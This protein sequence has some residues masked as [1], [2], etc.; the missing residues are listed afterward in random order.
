[1]PADLFTRRPVSGDQASIT[2]GPYQAAIA[3][4]G[5]S[6]RSLTY[7]GRELVAG[8]EANALRPAFRGAVLVPWPNRIAD[9]RYVF[10][11]VEYQVPLNEPERGNALHGLA[12]WADWQIGERDASSVTF[13]YRLVAQQAYPADLGVQATYRLDDQGLHWSVRATNLG[14]VRAPFALGSHAYLVAGPGHVDDWTLKVPAAAV[15]EVTPDRLLPVAERTVASFEG[16][17]LDFRRPRAIGSTFIDHAFTDVTARADRLARVEL[18]TPSGEG[19]AM[20]WDP[21]QLPWVQVHTADRPEPELNRSGLAVEPMT[22][23]PDAFN[24]G[25]DLIVLEPGASFASSWT[26][27]ALGEDA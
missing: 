22:C 7:Q 25:N 18:R 6:L 24:S 16:G 13:E 20:T 26:I 27:G 12:I 2:W 14:E 19:V 4:V 3:S 5:A 21:A 10:D 1:M 23:P 11:G 17:T 9:G 15:L 8:F